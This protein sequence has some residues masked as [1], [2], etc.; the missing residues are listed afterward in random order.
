VPEEVK[1]RHI[2]IKT[3]TPGADGKVDQK[4]VDAAKA[5]AEDI[6]Q[7]IKA[8]GN[9]ADLAKKNSEDPGSAPAGGEL[10]WIGRG[11]TVPEFEK[12]A[13]SLPVGQ[14]SGLVQ[15][16]YGF[17]I[18]QVEDKHTAHLKSLDEVQA[19]IEPILAQQKAASLA[20]NL[21]N[22]VQTAARTGGMA[23]AA[24]KNGLELMT[25]PL[26]ARTDSLAGV[27]AA[28]EFMSAVFGAQEKNPPDTVRL[29]NGYAVFQVLE[30]TPPATPTFEQA[31]A[32]VEADFKRERASQLLA[33]KLQELSDRARAQHELKKA[34]A[35]VGATM[36][37]SDLLGPDSQAPDLGSLT[38]PAAVVFD[39]KPGEITAPINIPR[40]GA[41]AM[42]VDK[43]EPPSAGFEAQ[44]EQLRENLLQQK[45][46]EAYQ[47]FIENLQKNMEKQG[48]IRINQ[49]EMERLVPKQEAS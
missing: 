40:G 13:F 38:G 10:G 39:L 43:E 28:P 49:K 31:K 14:T 7:K 16:S 12:T 37:S 36:H 32:R 6:L 11:R 8:G 5:K 25:S 20:E 17:H 2:L 24:A 48:K 1:V 41:V 18:I 21:A 47:L 9:F 22:T 23:G 27:G 29:P 19:Q 33:Q 30:I 42:V 3:P 34:A 26:V 46:A 35:E 15:S 45:R 44:K 4:A